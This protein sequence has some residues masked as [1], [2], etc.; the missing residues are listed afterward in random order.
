MKTPKN[1]LNGRKTDR[2][3]QDAS[4]VFTVKIEPARLFP[5]VLSRIVAFLPAH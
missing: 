4:T 1:Y 3:K 5:G 2:L